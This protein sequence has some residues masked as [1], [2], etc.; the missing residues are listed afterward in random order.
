[1]NQNCNYL[2]YQ[3]RKLG[4][5]VENIQLKRGNYGRGI[6]SINPNLKSSI[7]VP[8]NLMI[9]VND[10]NLINNKLSIKKNNK[11][12]DKELIN[13]INLYLDEL[14]WSEEIQQDLDS[15]EKD[16]ISFNSTIRILLRNF[17][18]ID[19]D[20][21]HKGSWNNILLKSFLDTRKFKIKDS[22]M[23]C[24]FLDLLNHQMDSPKFFA[25]KEGISSPYFPPSNNE[26]TINYKNQSSIKRLFQYKFFSL[27]PNVFSFP[28]SFKLEDLNI[29]FICNGIET[30]NNS[31]SVKRDANK[32]IIDG[33]PIAFKNNRNY[34]FKYFDKILE[35]LEDINIHPSFIEKI[36]E[37][38][39]AMRQIM[40]KEVNSLKN[41]TSIQFSELLQH[42]IKSI[43][44]EI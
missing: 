30:N 19:I 20:K 31:F 10:I 13:F 9:D 34:P 15:F 1:M 41:K 26:L 37:Y 38:N 40:K 28:F 32:V 39:L 12:Y 23:I 8:Y 7:F 3:F 33:L 44:S 36:I 24:P 6:F 16:L 42:E 4:G 29:I 5:K 27:E 14:C 21:R 22:N 35:T 17:L 25:G 43:K 11:T 18:L 2:I